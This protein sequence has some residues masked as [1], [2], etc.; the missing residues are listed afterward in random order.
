MV[1][2]RDAPVEAAGSMAG[3]DEDFVGFEFKSAAT[4]AKA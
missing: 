2:L 3:G 4:Y 1:A